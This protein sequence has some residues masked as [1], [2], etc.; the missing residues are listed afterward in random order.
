MTYHHPPYLTT[1]DVRE[2]SMGGEAMSQSAIEAATEWLDERNWY[3]DKIQTDWMI[4]QAVPDQTA[5]YYSY[6]HRTSALY[7]VKFSKWSMNEPRR[8]CN[9]QKRTEVISDNHFKPSYHIAN[10]DCLNRNAYHIGYEVQTSENLTW[11]RSLHSSPSK[12]KP[13]TWR[14]ETVT[15]F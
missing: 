10:G 14:R 8:I 2:C 4:V 9:M 6:H 13:C 15:K 3:E 5:V 12:G 11:Q 1:K 7:F